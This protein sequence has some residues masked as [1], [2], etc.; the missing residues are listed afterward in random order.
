MD[1]SEYRRR[2]KCQLKTGVG[3]GLRNVCLLQPRK[4]M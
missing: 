2:H 3:M 4:L 1:L